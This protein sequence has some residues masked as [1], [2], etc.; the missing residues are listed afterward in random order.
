MLSDSE[1]LRVRR[2]VWTVRFVSFCVCVCA[3][4][5]ACVDCA[6]RFVCVCVLLYL[7]E[8]APA[9]HH[10]LADTCRQLTHYRVC[11]LL[12][13]PPLP[14][15]GSCPLCSVAYGHSRKVPTFAA[16]T[17]TSCAAAAAAAAHNGAAAADGGGGTVQEC[18]GKS[19]GGERVRVHCGL[20]VGDLVVIAQRCTKCDDP[21]RLVQGTEPKTRRW[22]VGW[23]AR[24][25]E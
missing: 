22:W 12:S 15:L 6:F 19:G 5:R 10:V 11:P 8:K 17:D 23:Q 16:A 1:I 20:E 2:C 13:I 9:L 25:R 21:N 4:V 24:V 7:C 14:T 18:N 3:C